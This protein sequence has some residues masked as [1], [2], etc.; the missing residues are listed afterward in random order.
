[1][2]PVH[3]Q[4]R[5]LVGE[6]ARHV[7]SFIEARPILGSAML[8]GVF[9]SVLGLLHW[10][11]RRGAEY[12]MIVFACLITVTIVWLGSALYTYLHYPG[13]HFGG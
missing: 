11:F 13:F 1:M 2:L 6:S 10:R 9:G 4:P 3:A 5:Y 8:L 12:D 7:L